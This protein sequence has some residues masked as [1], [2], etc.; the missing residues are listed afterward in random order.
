MKPRT[1]D[2][3]NKV[4]K[5]SRRL[6]NKPSARPNDSLSA[7]ERVFATFELLEMILLELRPADIL[8]CQRIS[9]LYNDLITNSKQLQRTLCFD[10]EPPASCGKSRINPFFPPGVPGVDCPLYESRNTGT[11]SYPTRSRYEPS[12]RT[13][14]VQSYVDKATGES[15]AG[16]FLNTPSYD[17][18]QPHFVKEASWLRMYALQP[19]DRIG[20]YTSSWHGE[21][22]QLGTHKFAEGL[23]LGEIL[24]AFHGRKV[25]E[26]SLSTWNLAKLR[27]I[28]FDKWEVCSVTVIA[29][30]FDLI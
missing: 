11:L 30:R 19:P 6:Q 28:T 8:I 15:N 4:P 13:F 16:L 27:L 24:Q 1:V 21:P 26:A 23:K 12:Q 10:P 5:R 14:T 20:F 2:R 9:K 22:V 7:C 18:P 25:P 29:L 3:D 17:L